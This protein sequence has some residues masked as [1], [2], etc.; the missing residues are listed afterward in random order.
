M[1]F[2]AD[3]TISV[4]IPT[5]NAGPEFSQTLAALRSQPR[6]LEIVVVDSGSSDGTP[7]LAREQGARVVSIAPESF[8]HGETRNFGIRQTR[9]QFCLMLVQDAVPQGDSWLEEMLS[10][11]ADERVAGV[12]ARQVPRPDSDRFARWQCDYRDRFLGTEL[13]VQ[14]L[15]SWGQFE[16]LD[17]QERLRLAVFDNVCSVLRRGIWDQC[18]FRAMPFAEDLDWGLR[19]IGAG[20]RLV[21]KPS[22]CVMHS[23]ARP[24]AYHLRR[25]YVSARTMPRILRLPPAETR[26]RNDKEFLCAVGFLCGE[27]R[28]MLSEEG[29]WAGFYKAY[30]VAPSL[31]GS[32]LAAAGT[33]GPS[34]HLNEA[35]ENFYYILEDV[36]G[37]EFTTVGRAES[38]PVV[39]KVLAEVVGSYAAAYHNWREAQHGVSDGMRR[40]A[41]VLSKGV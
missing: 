3:A 7:D 35:R 33:I 23:H 9:G 37:S 32:L 4:V 40:L 20:Q 34:Y 24:A 16:T 31:L 15:E 5:K 6:L 25:S 14:E 18:P 2:W 29:D 36:L 41:A 28:A 21:Y 11:F 1:T 19:A 8:N 27:A 13:R 39:V 10:P 22:V 12:T 30:D 17:Y 26:A 38:D